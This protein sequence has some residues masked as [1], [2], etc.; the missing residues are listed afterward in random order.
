M[1]AA[2]LGLTPERVSG[3]KGKGRVEQA[4]FKLIV[5]RLPG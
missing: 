3:R 4:N 5:S 2:D 1:M